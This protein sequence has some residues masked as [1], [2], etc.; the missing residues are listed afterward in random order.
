[1][2]T[3]DPGGLLAAALDAL[4]PFA[5]VLIGEHRHDE[6]QAWQMLKV[7]DFR[8]ARAVRN[9]IIAATGLRAPYA[10]APEQRTVDPPSPQRPP[11]GLPG[12]AIS[13]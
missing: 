11:S 4:E 9:L 3:A 12:P 6:E 5:N 7:R 2:R 13:K 1:M 10:G 8:E